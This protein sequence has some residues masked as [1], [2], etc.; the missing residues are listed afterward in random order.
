L[1]DFIVGLNGR[2]SL[3]FLQLLASLS[4]INVISSI[5]VFGGIFF[6]RKWSFR[7]LVGLEIGLLD[8]DFFCFFKL[9]GFGLIVGLIMMVWAFGL[10]F[11][12]VFGLK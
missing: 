2:L 9:Q 3:F 6:V 7:W 12:F 10:V 5:L 8:G 4:I 11:V 1:E